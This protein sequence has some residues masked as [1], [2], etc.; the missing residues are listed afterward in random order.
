MMVATAEHDYG[1]V[2]IV[3]PLPRWM[4]RLHMLVMGYFLF[5]VGYDICLTLDEVIEGHH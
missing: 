3:L 1:D 4:F 2:R 5:A